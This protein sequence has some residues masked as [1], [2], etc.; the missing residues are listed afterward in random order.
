[1][2]GRSPEE[3]EVDQWG[4]L[5]SA[6]ACV[7]SVVSPIT[8]GSQLTIGRTLLPNLPF[9]EACLDLGAEIGVHS[10]TFCTR[11]LPRI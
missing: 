7:G 2:A 8:F 9:S 10:F 6:L 4:Y 5:W 3:A 1:M 11:V